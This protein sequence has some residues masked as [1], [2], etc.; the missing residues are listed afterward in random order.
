[1]PKIVAK[2]LP[3]TCPR[4][5]EKE[6]KYSWCEINVTVSAENVENVVNPPRKPVV[7]ARRAGSGKNR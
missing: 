1:M 6:R 7:I 5:I 3:T 2:I 4:I